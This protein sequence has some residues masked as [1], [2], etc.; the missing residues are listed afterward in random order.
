MDLDTTIVAVSA[1]IGRSPRSLVRA[2]GPDVIEGTLQLG[3][4][5]IPHRMCTGRLAV[6]NH[7]LPVML[8]WFPAGSSYTG[9]DTIE[10]QLPNNQF[11]IDTVIQQ[12]ID[13]TKGRRAEAGEF[14]ARA[15]FNGRI[16]LTAAEGVCATISANNEAE[17]L[18]AS[19]LRKG[20][21]ASIVDT[22]SSE[23]AKTL[24]KVEAG[25]DFTDEEDVVAIG[26][27][28]L[29]QSIERCIDT[30]QSTLDGRIAMATLRHLPHVVLCGAPNA[31]KSTL[32]N[33]L[34]GERRVVVSSIAG[35]TRDAISEPVMFDEKEALL[36]DIAGMEE[37]TDQLSSLAQGSAM[38]MIE[39]CDLILW[40][41][42]PGGTPPPM[43]EA[44]VVHTK[45]DMNNAHEDAICA[46]TNSGLAEF[47]T[48]IAKLLTAMPTPREDALAILPRHEQYLRDSL[49][50]LEESLANSSV[51]ELVATSLRLSLDAT[52]AISGIITPDEVLGQ[53]FASFCIGK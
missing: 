15:F 11:L 36:T 37:A 44:I 31:G 20:A 23:I 18:G 45:S 34:L 46:T 27:E 5:P 6:C 22:V 14:T 28:E 3:L 25:I 29:Q 50:C 7:T 26:Q 33:A 41:V 48:R 1:P 10:I 2:S 30:I 12:L 8:C 49:S 38:N 51:P 16:S 53:V 13:A 35:T 40:C 52:G 17:L 4:E 43:S 39:S 21:L 24:A 42:E 19:L 9:Q 32:F 47:R